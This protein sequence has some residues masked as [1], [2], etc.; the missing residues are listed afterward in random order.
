M[1]GN[2]NNA[3]R[4]FQLKL[5]IADLQQE[6]KPFVQHLGSLTSIWNELDVY[7]P[8]TT[9][10]TVLLKRVEEDKIFQLLASLSSNYEDLR[11]HILMNV[12]LSS[13]NIVCAAIQREEFRKKVMNMEN[14]PSIFET[15]AYVSNLRQVKEKTYKG[16][17]P[18]LKC[19][20]CDGIGHVKDRCWVLHHQ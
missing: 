18:D 15:R 5:D 8:H 12:E 11:S 3:A 6:G 14:K 17:R 20:Y 16:K 1:Y 10:A 7:R 4:V 9:D 2:Q 19:S 13:F